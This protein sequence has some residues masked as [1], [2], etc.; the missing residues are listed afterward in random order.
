M[1]TVG[2]TPSCTAAN[3]G[4]SCTAAVT[5]TPA[6]NYNGTDSFTYKSN[7]GAADSA[8]AAVSLTINPVPEP[9]TLFLVGGVAAAAWVMRRRRRGGAGA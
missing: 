9:G 6:A 3:G 7:D 5:Y 1:A 4:S 8:A 2:N